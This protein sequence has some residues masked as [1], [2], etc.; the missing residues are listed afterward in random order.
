[1]LKVFSTVG[2]VVG[3]AEAAID[4]VVDDLPNVIGR[5]EVCRESFGRFAEAIGG[6]TCVMVVGMKMEGDEGRS[7][8]GT[9]IFGERVARLEA[10]SKP[11]CTCGLVG[12]K[13]KASIL[14]SEAG[15]VDLHSNI[16]PSQLCFCCD[17]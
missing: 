11:R 12:V 2:E 16:F 3:S 5:E 9:P 13:G 6:T 17:W 15:K 4:R 7:Y 14:N 8:D 10:Q 1:L